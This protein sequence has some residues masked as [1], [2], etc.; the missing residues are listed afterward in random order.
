MADDETTT[1]APKRPRKAAALTIRMTQETRDKL[2]AAAFEQRRSV[3]E[4]AERWLDAAAEGEATY[5][6][7]IG[8]SSVGDAI[9]TMLIFASRVKKQLGDPKMILP[10]R[11]A[12]IAGWTYMVRHALVF[13]PET[14]EGEL[15]FNARAD[16]SD[17]VSKLLDAIVDRLHEGDLSWSDAYGPGNA[18]PYQPP[19]RNNA[20]AAFEAERNRTLS[21]LVQGASDYTPQSV[22]ALIRRLNREIAKPAVPEMVPYFVAILDAAKAFVSTYNDYMRPRARAVARG[23]LLAEAVTNARLLSPK[24]A[25][26][27][28]A[29][30]DAE[31]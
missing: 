25:E 11:D 6:E 5:Q 23:R 2:E 19:Q 29:Q 10:A 16:L 14:P 9:T 31:I 30:I 8:S 7:R 17:A 18:E 27:V 28:L 12:L 1:A 26:A 4:V 20:L 13:T 21:S 3:S 24:E 15:H 22:E